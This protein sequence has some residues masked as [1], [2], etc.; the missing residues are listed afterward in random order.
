MYLSL[1]NSVGFAEQIIDINLDKEIKRGNFLIGLKQY[2][3]KNIMK[4]DSLS[5]Q[6]DDQFISVESS[7]GL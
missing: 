5:L 7:N 1:R 2:L 3:G 6:T 4:E